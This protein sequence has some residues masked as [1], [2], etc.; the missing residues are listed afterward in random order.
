MGTLINSQYVLTALSC[1]ANKTGSDIALDK[2][3]IGKIIVG[4]EAHPELNLALIRLVKPIRFDNNTLPACL[5]ESEVK[6]NFMSYVG[7]SQNKMSRFYVRDLSQE[8]AICRAFPHQMIC[9]K[10][11]RFMYTFCTID[12]GGPLQ[13]EGTSDEAIVGITL[14]GS[15]RSS[16]M[17]HN[18]RLISY[19]SYQYSARL[20][21]FL[22][23]IR[24]V[25][26]DNYCSY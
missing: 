16:N 7:W 12:A 19:E 11:L 3:E 1:V 9:S 15:G 25:V 5:Y 21:K 26:Q 20:T 17:K 18:G 23:W 8:D 2:G 6:S 22:P 4:P 14:L 24:S 10:T 13:F